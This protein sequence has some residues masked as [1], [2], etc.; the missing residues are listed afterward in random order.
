MNRNARHRRYAI[1]APHTFAESRA[2]TAH[3]VIAY[4]ADPVV[5]VIDPDHAGKRVRDVV[6]YLRSDAPIVASLEEALARN[7]TSLLIG[8][9]PPGGALPSDWR[10]AIARALE[11]GLDLVS[12]LHETLGD[13]PEFAAAAQRGQATIWDVR[14]PP[15]VPLFSGRAY[16]VAARVILTVGSDCAVGKMTASLELVRTARERG[17]DARFVATGQTGIMIAGSGIAIDRVIADFAPGAAE[18]L[19]VEN[20]RHASLL[21]VEGQGSINHPAF[22]PVT[23]ALL[24]GAA[25]DAL[26]LV[27]RATRTAIESFGTPIMSYRAL[28]RTYEGLCATVKPAKVAGI[29]LNTSDLDERGARHAIERARAETG[30]PADDVVRYGGAG[31]YDAMAPAFAAKARPLAASVAP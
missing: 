25:P 17:A 8:V 31:L 3:G 20:A 2:K 30:L 4:G 21:F 13:D 10:G 22:A 15:D 23:L 11:A 1:L 26:V 29:A 16:G 7:P 9:A 19:V 14:L 12:G 24:Y 27:H 18:M 6:G 28:I 5:A